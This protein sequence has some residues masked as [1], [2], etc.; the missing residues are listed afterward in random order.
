ML[1]SWDHVEAMLGR[2]G[3]MMLG[4]CWYVGRGPYLHL[5]FDFANLG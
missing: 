5:L 1:G 4:L 2:A 3:P